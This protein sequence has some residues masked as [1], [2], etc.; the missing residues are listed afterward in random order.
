M[1]RLV[2]PRPESTASDPVEE[3]FRQHGLSDEAQALAS[4]C[5]AVG[6]G[7]QA[8]GDLDGDHERVIEDVARELRQAAPQE[9]PTDVVLL[10]AIHE[11]Q[12]APGRGTR[13]GPSDPSAIVAV[14][15]EEFARGRSD[16][17][18]AILHAIQVVKGGAA[19]LKDIV[20]EL[21]RAGH[22]D[23]L[24]FL[25]AE[26]IRT[27]TKGAGGSWNQA[28][29]EKNPRLP[30]YWFALDAYRALDAFRRLFEVE[31][32]ETLGALALGL[33]R[34]L[35]LQYPGETRHLYPYIDPLAQVLFGRGSERAHQDRTLARCCWS[36]GRLLGERAPDVL[37]TG[38]KL[39]AD[40][41]LTTLSD[42]R[43]V[44]RGADAETFLR[45]QGAYMTE[46][47]FFGPR[48]DAEALWGVLRRLFLA[49]REARH[50]GVPLDLR[51]WNE[52]E[53]TFEKVPWPWSW[54]VDHIARVLEL[55][56]PREL[57]RDP[58]LKELRRQV[59]KFFVERI[60]TREKARGDRPLTNEVF[61]EPDP[62]WRA[63]YVNAMRELHPNLGERGHHALT[64]SRDHD[65]DEDVRIAAKS[66]AE[67]V[68]HSHGLP[69]NTS[70][71]RAM[72]AAFWWLRQAHVMSLGEQ[73]DAAGAQRTFRKEMRRQADLEK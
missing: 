31:P 15:V 1:P 53:P 22:V 32:I 5:R 42:L 59:A 20:G 16:V 3:I 9:A 43:G 11:L 70:P 66:A 7:A 57:D 26:A 52:H 72:F 50:R 30:D 21:Y 35:M 36:Y 28:E 27:T 6:L 46:A 18:D 69:K 29:R 65:P 54:V 63:A 25:N 44:L 56:L 33:E 61:V 64:W 49:L 68:R 12:L 4:I 62:T 24:R 73:V 8:T 47:V 48:T 41:A 45:D 14:A 23:P 55:L 58:E 37:G 71:R 19:Q 34:S 38:Y 67:V 2:Q 60:K 13:N 51:T 40:L 39:L 10:L 17:S